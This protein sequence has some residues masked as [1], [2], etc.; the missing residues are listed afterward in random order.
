M[1]DLN[2]QG[3]SLMS[4]AS[5]LRSEIE[6]VSSVYCIH[7]VQSLAL[8]GASDLEFVVFWFWL[9]VLL[10]VSWRGGFSCIF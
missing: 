8:F 6:W 7:S 10:A 3:T 5:Q 4:K 2:F 9:V 1:F